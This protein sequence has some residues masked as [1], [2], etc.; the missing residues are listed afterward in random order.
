MNDLFIF[1][2]FRENFWTVEKSCLDVVGPLMESSDDLESQM[3]RFGKFWYRV[4]LI[5]LKNFYEI[6]IF[7]HL[8]GELYQ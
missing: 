1:F 3:K 5:L 8:I 2:F 4:I 6:L 7:Y